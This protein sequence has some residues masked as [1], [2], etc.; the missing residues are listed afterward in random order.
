[1]QQELASALAHLE[2]LYAQEN[3]ERVRESD[4]LKDYQALRAENLMIRSR[5]EGNSDWFGE[6]Q[7][8][9]RQATDLYMKYVPLFRVLQLNHT[10]E[11]YAKLIDK[12]LLVFSEAGVGKIEVTLIDGYPILK[13]VLND[14]KESIVFLHPKR[15]LEDG[16]DLEGSKHLKSYLARQ[17]FDAG[18]NTRSETEAKSEAFMDSQKNFLAWLATLQKTAIHDQVYRPEK[19]TLGRDTVFLAVDDGILVGAE[20]HKRPKFWGTSTREQI[21]YMAEAWRATYQKPVI[22][23]AILAGLCGGFQFSFIAALTLFSKGD[24]NWFQSAFSFAFG[25]GIGT[26]GK[27]YYNFTDRGTYGQRI[28]KSSLFSALYAIPIALVTRN[29]GEMNPWAWF[30]L[31][32]ALTGNIIANNFGKIPWRDIPRARHFD[33][34]N[35]EP[36]VYEW[37]GKRFTFSRRLLEDQFFYMIPW[38]MRTPDLLGVQI[39]KPLLYM[40]VVPALYLALRVGEINGYRQGHFTMQSRRVWNRYVESVLPDA[41]T[42]LR[43]IEDF[44]VDRFFYFQEYLNLFI[45]PIF[46]PIIE[47]PARWANRSLKEDIQIS[48]D[49]VTPLVSTWLEDTKEIK[50]ALQKG[51]PSLYNATTSCVATIRQAIPRRVH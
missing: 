4:P 25:F 12:D 49:A 5:N 13:V 28:L 19:I 46:K 31:A 45:R 40:S 6:N 50:R 15:G 23:D 11:E 26:F 22:E 43:N 38:S 30:S 7:E 35:S 24:V 51:T 39:G 21:Q 17:H 2:T 27:T 10:P 33:H 41:Y 47:R 36:I 29:I 48:R 1:M 16:I 42:K 8:A 3:M 32:A 37:F 14:F 34:A 20:Y 18:K 44:F 9:I